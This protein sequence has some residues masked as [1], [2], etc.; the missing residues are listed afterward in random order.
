MPREELKTFLFTYSYEGSDYALR[1]TA[2]NQQEAVGRVRRMS[3][4]IYDGEVIAK[5]PAVAGA[6]PFRVLAFVR[7]LFS[8]QF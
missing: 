6:W 5:M 3:T 2:S 1:V 4:A 7:N 8:P